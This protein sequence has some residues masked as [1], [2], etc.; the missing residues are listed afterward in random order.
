MT[1]ISPI[2]PFAQPAP[3][4]SNITPFT[5]R[6]GT[7]YLEYLTA[8][9]RYITEVVVPE[10]DANINVL[11]QAWYDQS[12]AL[13]AQVE[14]LIA[15]QNAHFD[16]VLED[17]QNN[18][19]NANDPVVKA[20]V[21]NP[22]SQTR[23]ALDAIYAT[24]ADLAT[25]TGRVDTLDTLVATGRL[26]SATLDSRFNAKAS[27]TALTDGLATKADKSTQDTVETGRL[28][29]TNLDLRYVKNKPTPIAVFIG[30]S[31]VAAGTWPEK[32]CT[33]MGWTVKNFC[34]SG[35]GFTTTADRSFITQINAAIA[36]TSYVKADVQYVF[37]ADAGNDMRAESDVTSAA[38]AVFS[39]A[40]INFPNAKLIV[41]PA[42]WG[43]ATDNLITTR[44]QSVT[45]R[46]NEMREAA[47]G[48]NIEFIE[49]SWLWHW[50][51][52]AW[53]LPGEVHYTTAGYD[54]I[55][56]FV[57]RY[58]R[59]EST[60]NPTKWIQVPGVAGAVNTPTQVYAKRT[61]ND[62]QVTGQF[63][64]T[65]SKPVDTSVMTLPIGL[66]PFN[67]VRVPI[68]NVATRNAD[69]TL[70]IF[71]DGTVRGFSTLNG[72]TYHVNF[73]MSAF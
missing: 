33:R 46:M 27:T 13:V 30:S 36:D 56:Y 31:N 20:L 58:L 68:V 71:P 11:S 69:A 55:V 26:S 72:A 18:A 63:G 62:I 39:T 52:A 25:L 35:G 3:F 40:K 44:L 67:E 15:E 8:L 28:S 21:E 59:N 65:G 19:I 6:D 66:R 45:N 54:R 73:T 22:T 38:A 70:D 53:M 37:I 23:I 34:I 24:D 49:W 17:L 1:M 2:T 32:L 43:Y 60:D 10:L 61:G 48:Y 42:L 50:D 64:T 7:T 51:S 5:Y 14:A 41:L 12:V 29:Q 47:L 16:E 57:E 9:Q 4:V